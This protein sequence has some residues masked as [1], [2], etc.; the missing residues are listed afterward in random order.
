MRRWLM[1]RS[2][3]QPTQ[4]RHSAATVSA[5]WN[6]DSH[7]SPPEL[8][9]RRVGARAQSGLSSAQPARSGLQE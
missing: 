9:S 5:I 4:T 3:A 2:V 7:Q 1:R 6:G 8:V